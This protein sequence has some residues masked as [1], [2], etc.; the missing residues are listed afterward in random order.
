MKYVCVCVYIYM[1]IIELVNNEEWQEEYS[2]LVPLEV[3]E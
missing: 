1:F 3:L 2:T